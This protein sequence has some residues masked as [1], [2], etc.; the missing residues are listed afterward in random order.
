M[1]IFVTP[2]EKQLFKEL[3]DRRA[4]QEKFLRRLYDALTHSVPRNFIEKPYTNVKY[5]KE[6]RAG[7]EMRGYCVFADEPP[8]YNFFLFICVTPH[9]YDRH[10]VQ[11]YDPDAGDRLEEMRSLTT[12]GAAEDYADEMKALDAADV[13]R[14]MDELGMDRPEDGE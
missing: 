9:E 4:Y 2:A 12:L 7:D 8:E 14:V 1:A 11:R 10:E 6:F 5:L 3:S 13:L